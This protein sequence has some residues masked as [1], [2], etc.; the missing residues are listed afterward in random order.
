MG[1]YGGAYKDELDAAK[2]VNQLC[3]EMSI[4]EKNPGIGTMPNQQLKAT[5]KTSQHEG[6]YWH[7]TN[8]KWY[9]W[10]RA[11]DGNRKYCGGFTDE[12]DAAK[13]MN[14]LCG[15]L[16]I[17]EK[18]P[19]IGTSPNFPYKIVKSDDIDSTKEKKRKRIKNKSP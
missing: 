5:K 6:V 11:K 19:G 18:N 16:E 9:V 7:K 13:K 17:V 8:K 2:T 12:V 4:P 1:T 3:E 10:L 14:Q 15:E